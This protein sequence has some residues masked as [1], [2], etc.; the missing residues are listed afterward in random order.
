[1]TL[2]KLHECI[3]EM[4]IENPEFGNLPCIYSMDDE[5]NSYYKVHNEPTPAEVEDIHVY[6]MDIE[7]Y[8]D[9]TEESEIKKEDIN[10]VV[11]N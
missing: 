5:G 2:R 8:W 3:T 11:I 1:M 6:S 10:C 4:L 9:G 7:G